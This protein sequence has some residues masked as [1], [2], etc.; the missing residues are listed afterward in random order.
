M[1]PTRLGAFSSYIAPS[2]V[3][4]DVKPRSSSN[5]LMHAELSPGFNSTT[6]YMYCIAVLVISEFIKIL[7]SCL[8][9][10]NK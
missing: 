4:V 6:G 9:T 5:W 7:F 1:M 10:L 2:S 8:H 3:V